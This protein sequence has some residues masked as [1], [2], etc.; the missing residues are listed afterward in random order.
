MKAFNETG[1]ETI[2]K[3]GEIGFQ[4]DVL[5]FCEKLPE[6]FNSWP[7]VEDGVVALGEA[8]GHLHQWHG[9]GFELRENPVTKERHLRLVKP[10]TL[11]HQ[12]HGY[13][14][15]FV[16]GDPKKIGFRIG[17]VK[18]YDHFSEETRKVAD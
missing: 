14:K 9:D 10:A 6:E 16:E 2:F 17:I 13:I 15:A 11:K 1:V 8:T 7:L 12:E 5:L 4:G 18:E 3:E